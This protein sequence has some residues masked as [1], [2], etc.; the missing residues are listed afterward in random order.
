MRAC[1]GQ[2]SKQCEFLQ[3]SRLQRGII[4]GKLDAVVNA[5]ALKYATREQCNVIFPASISIDIISS[6]GGVPLDAPHI[7]I[8]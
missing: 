1:S 3:A 2:L 4:S 6:Y 7:Y 5:E 8:G